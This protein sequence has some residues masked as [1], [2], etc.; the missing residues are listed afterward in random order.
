MFFW[1]KEIKFATGLIPMDTS[2]T[3]HTLDLFLKTS[4]KNFGCCN[5]KQTSNGQVKRNENWRHVNVK[6][7]RWW[8]NDRRTPG[9]DD[10]NDDDE[11][12]HWYWILFY[13]QLFCMINKS[14]NQCQL[15]CFVVF[16]FNLP[17]A[18][19]FICFWYFSTKQTH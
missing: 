17:V 6:N 19:L 5:K 10:N 9:D 16:F 3:N 1:G 8:T 11:D 14:I 4:K 13:H 15:N 2:I 12:R 18:C 7:H